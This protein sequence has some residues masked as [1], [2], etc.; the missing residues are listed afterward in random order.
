MNNTM[1]YQLTYFSVALNFNVN[2]YLYLDLWWY[3]LN[4][5]LYDIHK[6]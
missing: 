1:L 6:S 4:I 2:E 5:K 3:P